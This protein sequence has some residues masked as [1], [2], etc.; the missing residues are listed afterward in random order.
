MDGR[1]RALDNIFVERLWR[2][3]KYEDVYLR[4]YASM[5]ELTIG[6][7]KYFAYYNAERPYQSLAYKPPDI[8]YSSGCYRGAK[9]VDK[10][11]EVN[12]EVKALWASVCKKTGQREVAVC[13]A[14][15]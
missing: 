3:V 4:G 15:V 10:F 6:L 8:A 9:I 2:N 11:T 12:S 13:D 14:G 7:T 5:K 1:G